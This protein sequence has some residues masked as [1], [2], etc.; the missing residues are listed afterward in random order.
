MKMKIK[1]FKM[2]TPLPLPHVFM[3]KEIQILVIIA[4][5]GAPEVDKLIY[6][7]WDQRDMEILIALDANPNFYYQITPTVFR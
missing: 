4:L 1:K 7:D 6:R 5:M 3:L 2:T